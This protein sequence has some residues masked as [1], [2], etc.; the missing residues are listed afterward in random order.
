MVTHVAHENEKVHNSVHN[1]WEKAKVR[2]CS[3]L[4]VEGGHAEQAIPGLRLTVTGVC[5]ALA[6]PFSE[7]KT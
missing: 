3:Q 4:A 7:E 5:L 2:L 1:K 6:A